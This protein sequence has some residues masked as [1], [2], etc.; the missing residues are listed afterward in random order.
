MS[1]QIIVQFFC[2]SLCAA[3]PSL[4]ASSKTFSTFFWRYAEHLKACQGNELNKVR[5][6][7]IFDADTIE[8]G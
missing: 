6:V 7:L 4:K 2:A 1:H 3:I 5:S 8:I